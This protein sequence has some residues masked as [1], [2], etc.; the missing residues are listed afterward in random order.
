MFVYIKF[1]SNILKYLQL[2]VKIFQNI[3]QTSY[4]SS[5]ESSYISNF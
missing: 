3:F 2:E 1:S 5:I 4:I